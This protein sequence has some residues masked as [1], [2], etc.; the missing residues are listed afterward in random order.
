MTWLHWL[1]ASL[2]QQAVAPT[3]RWWIFWDQQLGCA[4]TTIM[5]RKYTTVY[6]SNAYYIFSVLSFFPI[7]DISRFHEWGQWRRQDCPSMH[8]SLQEY[9]SSSCSWLSTQ[10]QHLLRDRHARIQ[11]RAA[12]F[13]HLGPNTDSETR[14]PP[15]QL[16]RCVPICLSLK[17]ME[18]GSPSALWA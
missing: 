8:P 5:D 6:V 12:N 7:H 14:M 4:Q 17:G 10:M 15:S 1:L 16:R 2:S 11:Q 13:L 3:Q 18:P 9:I